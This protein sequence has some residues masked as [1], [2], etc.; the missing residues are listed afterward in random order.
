ML[1]EGLLPR[2]DSTL[3][4]L[5]VGANLGFFSHELPA[6]SFPLALERIRQTLLQAQG[7][8]HLRVRELDGDAVLYSG[9]YDHPLPLHSAGTRDARSVFRDGHLQAEKDCGSILVEHGDDAPT[10][11]D[12]N[13]AVQRVRNV[14]GLAVDRPDSCRCDLIGERL[15]LLLFCKSLL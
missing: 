12:R 6:A 4:M 3:P 8:L 11:N 13:L 2:G 1:A 14:A 15:F 7:V 5:S 10:V 9:L